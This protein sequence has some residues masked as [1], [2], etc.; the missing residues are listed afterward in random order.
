MVPTVFV[1]V[2]TA[3][4]PPVVVVVT[5]VCAVATLLN[6]SV[7]ASAR[8]LM[9]MPVCFMMV[10]RLIQSRPPRFMGAVTLSES[11]LQQLWPF[12]GLEFPAR[13]ELNSGNSPFSRRSDPRIICRWSCNPCSAIRPSPD[14]DRLL[15]DARFLGGT[16][17]SALA[18]Y[19]H[20]CR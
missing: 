11:L 15:H 7:A 13:L 4:A 1:V 14:R 19:G 8:A 17:Y 20:T 12:P 2:A 9:V 16:R 6:V 3:V 10:R 18:R 5:A